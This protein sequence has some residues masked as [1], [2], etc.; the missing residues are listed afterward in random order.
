MTE[1][2][3]RAEKVLKMKPKFD[4]GRDLDGSKVTDTQ[5]CMISRSE[6]RV[7][8]AVARAALKKRSM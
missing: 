8:R 4:Y 7:I 5:F 6:W 1:E 2:E 3:A